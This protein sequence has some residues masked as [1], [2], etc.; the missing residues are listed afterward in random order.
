MLKNHSEIVGLSLKDRVWERLRNHTELFSYAGISILS[1]LLS[2]AVLFS[3]I[4]PFGVAL[5]AASSG[6]FSIAAVL[7]AV[8]GTLI[9]PQI[10]YKMKYIAAILIVGAFKWALSSAGK[11]A[12]HQAFAALLAFITLGLSGTSILLA[13]H[14]VGYDFVLLFSEAVI[15]AAST[16]FFSRTFSIIEQ[17]DRAPL[18]RSDLSCLV[19]TFG[20]L[21]VALC[22]FSLGEIS[23]GRI[24]AVLMVLI[25]SLKGAESGGAIGGA[26][27]GVAVCL[28][29]GSYTFLMGAYSFGGLIAGVFSGFGRFGCAAAFILT[30]GIATAIAALIGPT[31]LAPVYEVFIAS[32]LFVLIPSSLLSRISFVPAASQS[33]SADAVK[34]IILN[35]LYFARK[36]LG[37]VATIT[38]K[39]SGKLQKLQAPSFDLNAAVAERV[40]QGCPREMTCWQ[41]GFSETSSVLNDL[42][43]LLRRGKTLTA[44]NLPEAFRTL[45]PDPQELVDAL[46]ECYSQQR[47]LEAGFVRNVQLRS[48]VL[49]Q[50]S[51]VEQLIGDI[52]ADISR[53]AVQDELTGT[54]VREYLQ[55]RGITAH[56]LSCYKN[57]TD[58]LMI[59][60]T[61]A[62]GLYRNLDKTE[63]TF[64]LSEICDREFSLP[65]VTEQEGTVLLFFHERPS[66][67]LSYGV[68]QICSTG[69]RLCGDSFKFLEESAGRAMVILSDGMGSGSL[70][71]VDSSMATALISRLASAGI[72]LEATLKLVNSAMLVKSGDES[73]A[74]VDI[75]CA[76]LYSG[77]ITLYKAG[78]APSYIRK[79]G[80]VGFV[81]ASSLPAGILNSV[82][83]Q[84]TKLQLDAGDIVVM[85]SDG[86]TQ[87][88][89]DWVLDELQR[90]E[91]SD[92]QWLC[93]RLSS[94]A[95]LRRS[96]AHDDDIT[97]FALMLQNSV[98]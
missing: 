40:C 37:E 60:L 4:A 24:A 68:T 3:K 23:V 2:N 98:A 91:G 89:E 61:V 92:M 69:K 47:R 87:T 19:I 22:A 97:V 70:A 59:E 83:F 90:F 42:L 39:V 63:L 80:K 20:L 25:C 54:R 13:G 79:A 67:K 95:K 81:E 73:L 56:A 66:F 5:A 26:T 35:R 43:T 14:P 1:F 34:N 50:W 62:S 72:G 48:V 45:C 36:A 58:H 41:S 57:E 46:T 30:N 65:S 74:T 29:E 96:E 15:A 16:F 75:C 53:I 78:A 32:I 77:R 18:L 31:T 33:I 38:E 17:K 44:D 51:G 55:R 93:E 21:I 82:E 10:E 64:D 27:A 76:D 28:C 12:R 7:G 88:G 6:D 52:S 84:Q 49:D 94:L 8:L 71:A 9:S 86:V 85:I 11:W